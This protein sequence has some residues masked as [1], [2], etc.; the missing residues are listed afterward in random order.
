M[1]GSYLMVPFTFKP[2]IF[3]IGSISKSFLALM[4]LLNRRRN[5]YCVDSNYTARL[6][7]GGNTPQNLMFFLYHNLQ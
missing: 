5:I 6:H 7:K 2:V 3:F 4:Q 1:T